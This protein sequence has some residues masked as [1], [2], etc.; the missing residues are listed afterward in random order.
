MKYSGIPFHI[1]WFSGTG[2]TLIIALEIRDTL[3]KYG[4][5]VK[6]YPI[7]KTDPK[8]IDQ[9]A[10]IGFVVPVA[11]QSTYPFIWEF[12]SDL[13]KVN[14][15][16]CFFVDTLG[17]YSGG[18][19]GPVKHILKRKGFIPL[20]AKEILMPNNFQKMKSRPE[21]EM[22]IIEKGKVKV[23]KFCE[24]LLT[25]KGTWWDIPVYS[26]FLSLMYRHRPLVNIFKKI[27]PFVIDKDKCTQCG[28][29]IDLCPEKSLTM[30]ETIGI[31]VNNSN[32]TLC[33][34]CFAY[35]PTHAIY[36]GSKKAVPYKALALKE[37]TTYLNQ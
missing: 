23:R 33:L 7:D 26:S 34:R 5:E 22:K 32:C 37:L 10:I 25:G 11:G 27:L 19:L 31:P 36:I 21:K 28:I 14:N 9:N 1:Y 29:C 3:L 30:D 35:C 16:A 24:K 15:T 13:P 4:C 6:L 18:I 8:T 12:I 2:N 17:Y 20:A